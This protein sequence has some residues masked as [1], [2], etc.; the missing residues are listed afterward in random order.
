MIDLNKDGLPDIITGQNNI[1]KNEIKPRLYVF[2]NQNRVSGRRS[3]KVHL[4]G[5]K[6]NHQGIGSMVMLYQKKEGKKIIQRRWV[7]YSQGGLMSQNEDGVYFGIDQ[8]VEIVGLKLRWPYSQKSGFKQGEVI[9]KLY[10]TKGLLSEKNY[11]EITLCED[12]KVL[13]GKMSCQF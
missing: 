13:P 10:P 5:I 11:S 7:E 6:S 4:G 12:G 3:L 9:E 8:N 1:R 2:E